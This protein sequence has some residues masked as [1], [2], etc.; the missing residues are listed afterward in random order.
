MSFMIKTSNKQ[1]KGKNYDNPKYNDRDFRN[2]Y[3][4]NWRPTK[5]M[6]E[7]IDTKTGEKQFGTY[8]AGRIWKEY[9]S[10]AGKGCESLA[11][12]YLYTGNEK[13]AAKGMDIIEDSIAEV[14][15]SFGYK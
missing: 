9:L 13:Y 6:P 5:R 8:L 12:A 15:K 4:G 3:I 10:H 14:E 2:S 1:L 11:L 7:I